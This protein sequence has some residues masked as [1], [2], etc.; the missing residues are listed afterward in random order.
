MADVLRDPGVAG[1][2][3]ILVAGLGRLPRHRTVG[4]GYQPSGGG[5][6]VRADGERSGQA[7][8]DAAAAASPPGQIKSVE[9]GRGAHR[10]A[11]IA[12]KSQA[13]LGCRVRVGEPDLVQ[14]HRAAELAADR[15][16]DQMGRGALRHHALGHPPGHRRLVITKRQP[17]LRTEIV[18]P[19]GQSGI[20]DPR[21]GENGAELFVRPAYIPGHAHP[22]TQRQPPRYPRGMRPPR[23]VRRI[24]TVKSRCPGWRDSCS[25]RGAGIGM[26]SGYVCPCARPC[27]LAAL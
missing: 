6:G 21:E 3:G 16:R 10:R 22:S 18:D 24:P 20:A 13:D 12:G 25:N 17:T 26:C 14:R 19:A 11:H 2:R 1:R 27:A 23:V 5:G 4:R 15:G 7:L 8:P 9:L